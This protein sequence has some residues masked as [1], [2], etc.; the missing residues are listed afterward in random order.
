VS[1]FFADM[2]AEPVL[3]AICGRNEDASG[4][5]DKFGFEATRPITGSCSSATTST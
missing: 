3:K 2:E 1:R 5:G 4:R